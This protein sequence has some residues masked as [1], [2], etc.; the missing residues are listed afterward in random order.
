MKNE[1][2]INN[3]RGSISANRNRV[4]NLTAQLDAARKQL[5]D[6]A[7]RL[8]QYENNINVGDTIE[9]VS[10]IPEHERKYGFEGIL[11]EHK[12]LP[13]GEIVSFSYSDY[14]GIQINVKSGNTYVVLDAKTKVKILSGAVLK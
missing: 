11:D 6:D 2:E 9:W 3:V 8:Y 12:P 14:T 4:I 7:I 13:V 5:Y 10:Y 1:Q